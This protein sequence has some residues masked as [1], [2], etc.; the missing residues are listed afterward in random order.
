MFA[1]VRLHPTNLPA[2]F[3]R[4][5]SPLLSA[6]AHAIAFFHG[7]RVRPRSPRAINADAHELC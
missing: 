2:I 6:T 1:F 5:Q 4:A 7:A 3:P